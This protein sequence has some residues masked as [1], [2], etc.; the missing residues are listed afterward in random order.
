MFARYFSF[1]P[2]RGFRKEKQ[3]IPITFLL[4]FLRRQSQQWNTQ[5]GGGLLTLSLSFSPGK[6]KE[7]E[8]KRSHSLD[9]RESV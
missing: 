9:A 5:F 1:L 8:R 2:F 7:E 3:K 4:F 6:I